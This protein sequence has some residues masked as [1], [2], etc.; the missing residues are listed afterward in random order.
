MTEIEYELSH[1]GV[2]G[3]K[4]GVRR[5]QNKDGSLTDVG[6]R[7][8][9]KSIAKQAND[10]SYDGRKKLSDGLY[11]DLSAN[12]KTQMGSHV[13]NIKS[14]KKIYDSL[15]KPENDYWDSGAAAKDSAKAYRQTLDHFK[16]HD[17]AYLKEI[18]AKNG[19]DTS[20]L[21]MYHDF[22]KTYEGFED[23]AWQQ[24]QKKFYKDR[25]INPKAIDK[26]YDD[27]K[28]ACVDAANDI[29]GHYGDTRVSKMYAYDT[30]NTVRQIVAD[31]LMYKDFKEFDGGV[32]VSTAPKN[33]R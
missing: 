4:W 27:Y 13:A 20:N 29:V 1:H 8:L 6:K 11:E 28:K 22:R 32:R 9:A 17:P 2:K 18:V 14:K 16:K 15:D 12:Y 10:T 23:H 5:F 7:R 19:G 26:A 30:N 31:T 24:G 33:T 21:D 3:M 25:G